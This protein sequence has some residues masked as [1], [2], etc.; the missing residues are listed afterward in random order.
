MPVNSTV[1]AK[2]KAKVK[3]KAKP[4]LRVADRQKAY[5]S[6][7]SITDLLP[8]KEYSSEAGCFLLNDGKSLG[9]CLEVAMIPVESKSEDYMVNLV[10]QIVE[11]IKASV[12]Q[13]DDNPYI[14]S[15]YLQDEAN[16]DAYFDL[17]KAQV[18]PEL[19]DNAFT[20][21]HLDIMRSHFDF[22]TKENGAFF[23]SVVTGTNFQ[24]KVRTLKIVIHRWLRETKN[25]RRQELSPL[26][27]LKKI[28]R[29]LSAYFSNTR[30]MTGDDFYQW[31]VKWFNPNPK[32]F[33]GKVNDLLK[34][35]PYPEN[36]LPYGWDLSEQV[37]FN[38]PV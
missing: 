28:T 25:K 29:D 19:A 18:K 10:Q 23:D 13:V 16:L 38:A 20:Q 21:K 30:L 15:C 6:Q 14:V 3:T 7:P 31:M 12:P 8:W 17:I 27:E 9:A 24:G 4:T 32:N 26:D 1:K 35:C 34:A 5:Q 36:E 22:L 2:E 33:Q 37:F 11:G